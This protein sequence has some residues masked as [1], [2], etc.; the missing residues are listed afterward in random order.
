M[1]QLTTEQYDA[2]ERAIATG[3]RI[4]VMRRGTEYIVIPER[5]QLATADGEAIEA[6]N[7]TTGD[8]LVISLSEIDSVEIVA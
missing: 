4:A 8:V 1:A 7:P 5:L 2:L 6:R 3:Q